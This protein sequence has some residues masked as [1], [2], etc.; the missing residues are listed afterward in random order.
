MAQAFI[1]IGSNIDPAENV[2]EAIDLLCRQTMLAGISM[3]YRSQALH[4]PEQP[5]YYNCVVEIETAMAAA[6]IK[7]DLLRPIEDALGR[8]RTADKYASRTI[9]LD[10]IVYDNL[11]L[12]G[13]E[14]VLPD[15]D[16]LR[17][18][19]LAHP[20]FELAPDLVLPGFNV[21]IREVAATLPKDRMEP[22]PGYT[23][24]LRNCLRGTSPG[25]GC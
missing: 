5:D 3:V 22:L 13:D 14:I 4:R 7:Q 15:P 24:L 2:R 17:R 6:R 12:D 10:L 19:F 8:V 25:D 21:P 1:A 23:S 11:K 18:P 16:I 20:L 9:D